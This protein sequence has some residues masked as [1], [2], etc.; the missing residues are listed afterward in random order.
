MEHANP[1]VVLP[2]KTRNLVKEVSAAVVFTIVATIA[3]VTALVVVGVD[4]IVLVEQLLSSFCPDRAIVYL[5]SCCSYKVVHSEQ[6]SIQICLVC[7]CTTIGFGSRAARVSQ[8]VFA[9]FASATWRVMGHRIILTGTFS[10]IKK[11]NYEYN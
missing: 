5:K 1:Q 8:T 10:G 9:S 3:I 6:S 2:N 7:Q 11:T 4:V